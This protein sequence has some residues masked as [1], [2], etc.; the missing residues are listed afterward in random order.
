MRMFQKRIS[1]TQNDSY[2]QTSFGYKRLTLQEVGRRCARKARMKGS[3][4]ERV[5]A[6]SH[7]ETPQR[8]KEKTSRAEIVPFMVYF[9]TLSRLQPKQ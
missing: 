8:Y 7:L 5:E 6:S 4:C 1:Q 9:M 2:T 3:H